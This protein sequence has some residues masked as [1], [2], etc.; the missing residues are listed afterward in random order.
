M[1]GKNVVPADVSK[2]MLFKLY[3]DAQF[4]PSY[5]ADGDL[6]IVGHYHAWVYPADDGRDIA[7]ASY[8]RSDMLANQEDKYDYINRVNNEVKLIRAYVRNNGGI[9]FDYY[10]SVEGGISREASFWP[11]NAITRVWNTRSNKTATTCMGSRTGLP[12]RNFLID[13]ARACLSTN[14]ELRDM[15]ILTP[16]NLDLPSVLAK[17]LPSTRRQHLLTA[18]SSRPRWASPS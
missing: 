4:E 5:D 10:I 15:G 12:R 2:A 17:P 8:L 11:P 14:A 7:V 3:H 6:E 18:C 13:Y 9:G 16:P 1:F